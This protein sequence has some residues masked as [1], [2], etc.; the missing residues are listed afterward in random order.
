MN[1]ESQMKTLQTKHPK[2][3][4]TGCLLGVEAAWVAITF[5]HGSI[6][7]TLTVPRLTTTAPHH[8]QP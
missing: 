6:P 3:S 5:A 7:Y 8:G 4:G 2:A 1:Q